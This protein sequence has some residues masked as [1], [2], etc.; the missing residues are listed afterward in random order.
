MGTGQSL[1]KILDGNTLDNTYC[2][3]K[4]QTCPVFRL[5]KLFEAAVMEILNW[6]KC[7]WG[8]LSIASKK[9]ILECCPTTIVFSNLPET[10]YVRDR[11]GNCSSISTLVI[12]TNSI[13]PT[14]PNPFFPPR[15]FL[16][17]IV[18][19]TTASRRPGWRNAALCVLTCD[20]YNSHYFF[21]VSESVRTCTLWRT[22]PASPSIGLRST[23]ARW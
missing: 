14:T 18:S 9:R 2:V 1:N 19:W 4:C 13:Q 20:M 3:S 21:Q 6:K 7:S 10:R 5:K 12:F 22:S 23:F 8:L 11:L 15:S 16:D 17:L